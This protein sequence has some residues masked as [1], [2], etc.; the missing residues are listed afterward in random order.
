MP[1]VA[2]PPPADWT[3]DPGLETVALGGIRASISSSFSDNF[4]DNNIDLAKWNVTGTGISE[5]GQRIQGIGIGSWDSIKLIS[6]NTFALI[7]GMELRFKMASGTGVTYDLF[8]LFSSLTYGAGSGAGMYFYGTGKFAVQINT[9]AIELPSYPY[10]ANK[11]YNVRIKYQNPG[12]VFYVQSPDDS[13]YSTETLVYS[14][15][16]AST[17]PF[18]VWGSF[19]NGTAVYWDDVNLYASYPTTGPVAETTWIAIDQNTL[20][21][22]T[23]ITI[24]VNQIATLQGFSSFTDHKFQW[25]ANNGS[26][27][28]AW[29]TQAALVTALQG[30]VITNHTNSLRLKV[31]FNSD[32]IQ[33][34]DISGFGS[35]AKASGAGVII[36]DEGVMS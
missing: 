24:L 13:T 23:P 30:L 21:A 2:L 35:Y 16:T 18:Y 7:A 19:Y 9:A 36:I 26:Y 25:A 34:S 8:G 4:D 32:G 14:T 10:L 33:P 20:D 31:Q 11:T 6:D 5:T 27:N 1:F 22:T 3:L 28:G 17:G 15:A 12:W 29:I